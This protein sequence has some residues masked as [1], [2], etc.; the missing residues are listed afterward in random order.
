P[1]AYGFI[2]YNIKNK[3]PAMDA[4]LAGID[5]RLPTINYRSNKVDYN[6]GLGVT[7]KHNMMEYGINYDANLAKKYQGHAGS[8]K[9]RVNL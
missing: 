2:N 4:R 6:L 1:E 5:E 8:I 3:T 9:V 7:I